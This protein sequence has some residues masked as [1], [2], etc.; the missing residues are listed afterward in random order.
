MSNTDTTRRDFI[1]LSVAAAAV[2][3]IVPASALGKDGNTAPSDRIVIAGIGMGGRMGSH[4]SNFLSQKQVQWVATCDCF[5]ARRLAAKARIDRFYGNKDCATT[6]FHEEVL[7]RGDVDAV[8]LATGDRWHAVLSAL[9]ARAGK[10]VY[11]E[12]PFSLTI[13]E[14]QKMVDVIKRYGTVWQCGTQMRSNGSFSFAVETIQKGRIGNL[15]RITASLGGGIGTTGPGKAEP[16]P[17]PKVFDY[18][19]WLG[20][21]PWAPYSRQIVRSWRGNWDMAG[22]TICD[23]GAHLFDIARWAVNTKD[24]PVEYEGAPPTRKR[25]MLVARSE[26][27]RARFANG[28]ELVG[29]VGDKEMRFEGDE[30][31]LY[32]HVDGSIKTKPASILKDRFVPK[33]DRQFMKGHVENFLDCI[34]TR[35]LPAAN[36]KVAQRSHIICHCANLALRLG[37]KLTWD[38][39]TNRFVGNDDANKML[40]RPMRAPWRI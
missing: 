26:T 20:Q 9:A 22:G 8:I 1:K 37:Q 17:D 2:P 24:A 6:R 5:A 10:D 36:A 23:L 34:K 11:C 27:A 25:G 35:E 18:D 28:V 21:A 16:I 31:W 33:V 4:L 39:A 12:K 3:M 14:G 32:I 38:N 15:R 13:A 19:R 7:A 29:K 40:A 30:G